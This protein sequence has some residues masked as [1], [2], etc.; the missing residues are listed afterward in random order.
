MVRAECESVLWYAAVGKN[1]KQVRRDRP[2]YKHKKAPTFADM[3]GA[4]PEP[5][6]PAHYLRVAQTHTNTENTQ[7]LVNTLAAVR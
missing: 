7:H 3:L 2:W 4:A 5:V 1:G 6:E